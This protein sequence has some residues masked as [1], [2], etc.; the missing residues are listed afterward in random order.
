MN[1]TFKHYR[2]EEVNT[3]LD[4]A[5]LPAN[6]SILHGL[7]VCCWLLFNYRKVSLFC[8]HLKNGEAASVAYWKTTYGEGDYYSTMLS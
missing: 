3:I 1:T 4:N 2:E 5:N 8:Y 7:H 6:L